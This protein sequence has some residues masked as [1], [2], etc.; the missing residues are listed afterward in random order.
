[1]KKRTQEKQVYWAVTSFTLE[2][3]DEE[4]WDE[5]SLLSDARNYVEHYTD[6]LDNRPGIEIEDRWVQKEQK[7]KR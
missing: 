1:M 5:E 6:V 2:T 7:K 4:D 3:K